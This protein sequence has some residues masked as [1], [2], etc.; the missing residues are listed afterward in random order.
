MATVG[1]V[2]TVG[3][4]TVTWAS[5]IIVLAA[6]NTKVTIGRISECL[7]ELTPEILPQ[8]HYRTESGIMCAALAMEKRAIQYTFTSNIKNCTLEGEGLGVDTNALKMVATPPTN[9]LEEVAQGKLTFAS[10]PM[11]S[12]TIILNSDL[13]VDG[14]DISAS[15]N[16]YQSAYRL[17][18]PWWAVDL[19]YT[20]TIYR[21]RITVRQDSCCLFRTHDI[22]VRVGDVREESGNLSSYTL[23]ST[24]K[25]PYDISQ[26]HIACDR[27]DGVSGRY[28]SIQRVTPEDHMLQ[29]VEV[30]VFASLLPN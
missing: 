23:F 11:I 25:G 16:F 14:D 6:H 13:A 5:V 3:G 10:T 21:V 28:I 30:K 20:R 22:E 1:W 9:T 17:V 8:Q 2:M 27:K 7:P 29:L 26:G 4:W 15:R 12:K 24:Y 19:S 18:Y